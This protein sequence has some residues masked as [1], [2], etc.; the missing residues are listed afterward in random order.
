MN[1]PK[2]LLSAILLGITVHT[3]TSC[4]D[5]NELPGPKTEKEKTSKTPEKN[6]PG[7]CPG[8]GMG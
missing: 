4:T 2:A 6:D 1:L 7:N 5:K 3:T 8:C